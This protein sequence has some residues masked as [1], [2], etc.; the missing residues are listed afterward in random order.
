MKAP[1]VMMLALILMLGSCKD[2]TD[3]KSTNSEDPSSN[4]NMSSEEK[5]TRTTEPNVNRKDTSTPEET[6]SEENSEAIDQEIQNPNLSGLYIKTGQEIDNSCACYCLNINYSGSPELCLT[7]SKIFINTRMAK[8]NNQVTNIFYVAPSTKNIEGK[9][10]PWSK[11]DKNTPIA[12]IT[13]KG[14]GEIDLDWL[15]FSIN[16]D[17]AIDYAILGKKSLEG[18]YK[19]K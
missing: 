4:T 17:L 3:S 15:G 9:D 2:S 14:N 16:G 7:P 12:T 11:F 19:K 6:R 5:I 1:A 18:N 13:S 8:S 10:I